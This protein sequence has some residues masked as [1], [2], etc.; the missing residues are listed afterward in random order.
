MLIQFEFLGVWN[1]VWSIESLGRGAGRHVG[2]VCECTNP[3][4]HWRN[5]Q[6]FSHSSVHTTLQTGLAIG[7]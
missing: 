6:L 3:H 1:E 7:R 4:S 5:Q 2:Y